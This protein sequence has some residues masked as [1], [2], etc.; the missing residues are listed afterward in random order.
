MIVM[1]SFL[2]LLDPPSVD[3]EVN[4]T[5]ALPV[6]FAVTVVIEVP[7]ASGCSSGGAT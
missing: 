7:G 4:V 1:T 3:F 5:V 2:V 6:D